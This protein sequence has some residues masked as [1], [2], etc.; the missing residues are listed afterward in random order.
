MKLKN[1]QASKNNLEKNKKRGS[2]VSIICSEHHW[3]CSEHHSDRL[4]LAKFPMRK[5]VVAA[6]GGAA[7]CGHSVAVSDARARSWDLRSI[8]SCAEREPCNV[9]RFG[10]GLKHKWDA[11]EL[12][13]EGFAQCIPKLLEG[14]P[15]Q[16]GWPKEIKKNSYCRKLS[17]NLLN[18][19]T[20]KS[21]MSCTI[22]REVSSEIQSPC[23]PCL[24][25]GIGS[26]IDS[27]AVNPKTTSLEQWN[28]VAW[29]EA[30]WGISS[31]PALSTI[32]TAETSQRAFA[33]TPWIWTSGE[34]KLCLLCETSS[35]QEFTSP[36]G[37]AEPMSIDLQGTM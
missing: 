18:T 1:K 27:D 13:K 16:Y 36:S 22:E 17:G 26:C 11:N 4:V 14:K 23:I 29:T 5:L 2:D 34:C 20:R 30:A 8:C 28:S 10:C 3:I 31:S 35:A 24:F 37:L 15:K 21:C 12:W 32:L 7:A 19:Y 33:D 9:E 25:P 6:S